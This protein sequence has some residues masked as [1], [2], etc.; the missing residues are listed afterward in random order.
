MDG[1]RQLVPTVELTTRIRG[2]QERL[3]QQDIDGALIL[4]K[5]DLYYYTGTTQAGWLYVPA[6]GDAV[7]MVQ[8]NPARAWVET[9]LDNV[10]PL[11]SPKKIPDTLEEN[12]LAVPDRMGMELDVL[13]VN[14]YLMF[15]DIFSATRVVDISFQIRLQRAVK[16]PFEIDCMRRAGA[17]ADEV[18]AAAATLIRDGI[19]EVELAGLVEAHA[20]KLGHQGHIPMRLFDNTL[21]YGHLLCGPGAAIPG[22][23]ASPTA[24]AGLNPSIGQGPGRNVIRPNQPLLVDYVFAL[25]GYLA[26]HA[27]IFSLGPLPDELTKAHDAMVA[28]QEKVAETAVPGAITGEIYEAMMQMADEAGYTKFFMGAAEPRIRFTAHGIGIELDE[29]PFIAKGQTLTLEAGMTIALEPK[30]ILPGKGV[31]GI[32]NTW[33]VTE[34]GLERLTRFPDDICTVM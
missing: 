31:V 18:A 32:E 21:F 15:C 19:P 1:I 16:S 2:L 30:V 33:L 17:L 12:G 5:A 6:D 29:F 24:G 22:S 10:I 7:F 13:P 9:G 14:Q 8:K 3:Q 23:L 25:D 28:I 20:R 26:D 27:R 11:M 4:Q 34:T